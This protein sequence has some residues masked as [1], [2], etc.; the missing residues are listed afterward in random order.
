MI[1]TI[2]LMIANLTAYAIVIWCIYWILDKKYL[3]R[4]ELIEQKMTV[5]TL[6]NVDQAAI[7]IKVNNKTVSYHY[8][9]RST[10]ANGDYIIGDKSLFDGVK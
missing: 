3:K 2:L 4:I 8:T 5:L 7:S 9:R 10:V 6:A 1:S